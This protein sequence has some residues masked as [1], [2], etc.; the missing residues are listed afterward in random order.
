MLFWS[1]V[2]PIITYCLYY[3][4]WLLWFIYS[5]SPT[6]CGSNKTFKRPWTSVLHLIQIL[7]RHQVDQ[8]GRKARF[9]L[10]CHEIWSISPD[11]I[12][13]LRHRWRLTMLSLRL[14]PRPRAC[15]VKEP[16]RKCRGAAS[17]LPANLEHNGLWWIEMLY[18]ISH[19]NPIPRLFST[20][21]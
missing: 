21:H 17:C 3:I 19:S 2:R 6:T 10:L 13:L 12:L 5:T 11:I 15:R 20:P 18:Y 8:H 16:R 7:A 14:Q 4:V 9:P 1:N